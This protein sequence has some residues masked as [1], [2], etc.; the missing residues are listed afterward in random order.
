MGTL[1]AIAGNARRKDRFS[2]E[3]DGSSVGLLSVDS[4]S[5]LG[6]REGIEID[7][8]KLA[9]IVHEVAVVKAFDRAILMLTARSRARRELAMALRRT[10]EPSEAIEPALERLD[11]LGYLD[12][13]AF[14][15]AYVRSKVATAGAGKGKIR[16][17]LLRKGV[18]KPIADAAIEEV[19]DEQEVVEEDVVIALAQKRL[20]SLSGLDRETQRRRLYGFLARRGF[21][22]DDV[23]R[24]VRAVIG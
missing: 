6:L 13:A 8:T 17:D 11:R 24:A 10:G 16:G 5:R 18:S 4:I 12:D 14:A 23:M 3:I 2:I 19:F 9:S 22:A 20:K 15:R 7:D 1:T 21:G